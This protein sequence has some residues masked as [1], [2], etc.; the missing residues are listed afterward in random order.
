MNEGS[1]ATWIQR[2]V[3]PTQ[4]RVRLD[5]FLAGQPELGTRGFARLAIERGQVR[6][7]GAKVRPGLMLLPGQVVEFLPI[8]ETRPRAERIAALEVPPL[9]VLHEDAYILV[10]HKPAGIP[11]H[12][13]EQADRLEISVA[14][15]ALVHCGHDLP[16][17]GG[18]DRPGIVHRLD[19][20]TSGVMVLAKTEESF[21]FLQAQ[22]K[23]RTVRKEYRA[24]A[25]GEAR[26][27]SDH[28]TRNIVQHPIHPDRML[29]TDEGGREA[30]TFYEVLERFTGFTHFRC[31]PKTGRTHQIRV[32]LASIGHSLVG[33][34]M[35]R[36]RQ[37]M[38]A[39]LP[40]GA[41]EPG[42]H[43]LHA[44]RLRF[45]HPR[46]HEEL[47]FD[48]PMPAEMERLLEWLREHRRRT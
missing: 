29:V 16:R 11:S 2:L 39:T 41:P 24:L 40:E 36:S 31:L 9:Q 3:A 5:V 6:V 33:D 46:T 23:A 15:M 1:Q 30:E 13:T 12:P 34:R 37:H 19:R 43:C 18:V 7:L 44:L 28:V 32:H 27:D 35:Y 14:D 4:A 47:E 26:F 45:A 22:F 20:E 8:P 38:H 21:H 48:A 17:M 25:H 10:I 42:R